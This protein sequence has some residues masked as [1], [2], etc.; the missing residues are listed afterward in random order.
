MICI[1]DRII[2]FPGVIPAQLRII[3]TLDLITIT[4]SHQFDSK[5]LKSRYVRNL[6]INSLS[7]F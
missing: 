3:E 2:A 7:K 6:E 1:F 4:T 5:I